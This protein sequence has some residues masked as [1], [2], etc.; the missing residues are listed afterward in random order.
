MIQRVARAAVSVEGEVVGQIGAGLFVLLGV[1]GNDG[2]EAVDWLATKIARLRVFDD[3]DGK[4][5]HSLLDTGRAALVVSQFTLWGNTKKGTRPS[6]NRAAPPDVAIPL[7]E[8]FVKRLSGELKMPVPTGR[9]GAMMQIDLVNDGP[10]TLILD[11]EQRD[12]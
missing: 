3:E 7:Y 10:V 8:A 1:G 11:T 2:P 5:N 9:F 4:M 12:F 6:Y